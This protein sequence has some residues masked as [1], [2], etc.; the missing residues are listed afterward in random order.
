VSSDVDERRGFVYGVTAYL[1]WGLFPLY[2]PL[3]K[4]ASAL[5]I[6][7]HRM[8]WSLGFVAILLWRTSGWANV[9]AIL[10]DREKRWLLAGAAVVITSNWGTY[11]WGVNSHHVVETSLGY[12]INPLFTILLGVVFLHERLRRMQW[13]AVGIGSVAIVVLTVGYGRLPWIALVLAF[14]FGMYGY[15]KKRAAVG[16]VESLAIETGYL[17]IPALTTLIVIQVHG[18]L[19][20]A[21]HSAGNSTLLV[22]T[23]V[24]TAI[25]LLFFGAAT[26]RLPLSVIG[27]LQYLAPVLQLAVGVTVNHEKMPL[28]RWVGFGL[29]WVALLVLTADG[30]RRQRRNHERDERLREE[31]AAAPVLPAAK[32]ER[33]TEPR[34]RAHERSFRR[35]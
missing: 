32:A 14:S 4:P 16:A 2:W 29:V 17:A 9:R 3:L 25:P 35:V 15:F 7:A 23:G 5:E 13:V 27:L 8:L 18:S 21:Q 12:F 19:V 30:I 31:P 26:R 22:L 6:L 24:I 1:L 34:C 20:F 28:E 10:A 33:Q 11:I